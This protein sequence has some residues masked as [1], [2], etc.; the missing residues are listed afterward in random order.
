[1]SVIRRGAAAAL[2]L[3]FFGCSK[4]ASPPA[5]TGQARAGLSKLALIQR[6]RPPADGLL[7]DAM[8]D[9][10]LKVRRAARGQPEEDAASAL[11][12]DPGETVWVEARI[13]E[14]LAELNTRRLRAETEDGYARAISSLKQARESIRDKESAKTL[15]EQ[16]V[17]LEKERASLKA[18]DSGTPGL[19]ANARRIAGR[20]AEIDSVRP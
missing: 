2:L 14:A 18:L 20:R 3:L 15:N 11:R 9:R 17:T 19:V 13:R 8:I 4:P 16:I 1:M 5:Q 7:T 12:A 10:Y 6:F